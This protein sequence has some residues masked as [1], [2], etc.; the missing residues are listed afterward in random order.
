MNFP[1]L[2]LILTFI[3]CSLALSSLLNNLY[4]SE[5]IAVAGGSITEIIYRLGEEQRI[6]GVDSTS[7]FNNASKKHPL[8]GYV[9][10]ISVEG[11]LSLK[12]DLLIG[13][14]DTGPKKALEQVQAVGLK[15][16][17]INE[18]D[19]VPAVK[20]KIRQVAE[21]LNLQAKGEALIKEIQVDIDALAYAKHRLS[22]TAS[23]PKVLFLLALSNGAPIAAGNNT[24]ADT[25]ITEAG[26]SNVLAAQKGWT[27]LSP[28]SAIALNPDIII[29]MNRHDNILEDVKALPHFKYTQAVKNKA[30]YGIDGGYLLGFGP[31]TPQAIVELG[32]LIHKVFPLPKDYQF[33]YTRNTQSNAGH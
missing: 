18:D 14:S 12:P 29:V 5:R 23:Q 27:K 8:L 3:F 1:K 25:V 21:L 6:V 24:S 17:I 20:S 2:S 13:E 9:R 32:T 15:T 19:T 10:N 16:V 28:E 4:A 31:R 11:L 26:G 7:T 22:K 33:R 30:V